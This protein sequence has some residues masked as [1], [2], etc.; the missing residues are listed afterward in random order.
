M[1]FDPTD[2][3]ATE[4]A[5]R[6]DVTPL[7]GIGE[8]RA[9]RGIVQP[10]AAHAHDHYVMGLVREGC[11]RMRCNGRGFELAPG[12][13]IVFNPDDVHGCEQSDGGVFAYDSIAIEREVLDDVT[14]AGP[15]V[16]DETVART[17]EG[18]L[19]AID[20]EHSERVVE[21]VRE[22]ARLLSSGNADRPSS[23]ANDEAAR[24]AFAHL[25]GHLAHPLSIEELARRE[26]LSKYALIRA[27]RRRFSITP[28][29][30]LASLRV[31]C[32]RRLLA[33]D[34]DPA[35]VAMETGFCDQAHL[36]RVFK[37]RMGVTPGA[38]RR[39]AAR[40]RK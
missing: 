28:L 36:T 24:H 2:T 22:L 3:D 17:L 15:R 16:R 18:V 34:V 20:A 10:F 8:R 25:C 4:K 26:G 40:A 11:R 21:G 12:D 35:C 23:R 38:Y 5:P 9:Y 31:D 37:Q 1:E 32:A 27:Y 6:C 7:P 39:M 30:H 13:V 33:G 19:G 14:L 29:Q